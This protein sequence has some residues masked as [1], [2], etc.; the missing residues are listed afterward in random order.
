[1]NALYVSDFKFLLRKLLMSRV[2]SSPFR[3][4]N[5]YIYIYIYKKVFEEP[6]NTPTP[7]HTHTTIN[8]SNIKDG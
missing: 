3:I 1:M 6:K 5:I 2:V 4:S 8:I 7:T